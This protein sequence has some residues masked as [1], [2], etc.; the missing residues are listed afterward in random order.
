M[1]FA[2]KQIFLASR[3][4]YAENVPQQ[5][6]KKNF[7]GRGCILVS[8]VDEF[9]RFMSKSIVFIFEHSIERGSQ[10]VILNKPTAFTLGESSPNI[11]VF[12][13]NTLFMGGQDGSDMAIMLHRYD[14]S[15]LAKYVGGGVYIGGIGPARAMVETFQASPKDFKFIFNT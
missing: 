12:E 13:S 11:G 15:G 9:D 4:N 14:F 2:S 3:S 8:K 1:K 10:G 7:D 6:A 5:I